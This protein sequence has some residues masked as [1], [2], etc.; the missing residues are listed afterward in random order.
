MTT[1]SAGKKCLPCHSYFAHSILLQVPHP[2]R[3]F[4]LAAIDPA[5]K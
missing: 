5:L 4:I 3:V 1:S 2:R